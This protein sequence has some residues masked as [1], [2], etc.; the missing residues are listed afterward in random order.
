[1]TNNIPNGD[2][3]EPLGTSIDLAMFGETHSG[4]NS[5]LANSTIYISEAADEYIHYKYI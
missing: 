5:E 1:M 2:D 4:S 3:E